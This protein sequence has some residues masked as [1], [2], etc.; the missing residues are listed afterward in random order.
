MNEEH[1]E[2]DGHCGTLRSSQ[3]KKHL[4]LFTR[5]AVD[6]DTCCLLQASAGH[7]PRLQKQLSTS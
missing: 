3:R 7:K 1:F 4:S 5:V 2:T 6:L